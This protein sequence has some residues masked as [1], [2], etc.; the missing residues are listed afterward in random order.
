[1]LVIK[2]F[3]IAR[4]IIPKTGKGIWVNWKY[5]IVP[6]SPIAQPNTHQAVFFALLFQVCLHD[7]WNVGVEEFT[8]I[9]Y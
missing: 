4:I 1:M 7:Q 8:I 9:W 2:P 6:K 5:K 3:I